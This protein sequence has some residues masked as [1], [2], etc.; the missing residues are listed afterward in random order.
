MNNVK[1][2]VDD[3]NKSLM[4]RQRRVRDDVDGDTG[5]KI[6]LSAKL[7]IHVSFKNTAARYQVAA[8]A[9]SNERDLWCLT[10]TNTQEPQLQPQ[11]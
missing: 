9:I 10:T 8:Q 7:S 4:R 5:D 1:F 2:F 6:G 3:N 11:P